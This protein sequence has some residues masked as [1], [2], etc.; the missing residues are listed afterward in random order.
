MAGCRRSSPLAAVVDLHLVQGYVVRIKH[1]Q[2]QIVEIVNI[3]DSFIIEVSKINRPNPTSGAIAIG[4]KHC[5]RLIAIGDTIQ[6][7]G[8][9]VVCVVVVII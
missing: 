5:C 1:S 7:N 2:S 9:I 6:D 3:V 8:E 4:M